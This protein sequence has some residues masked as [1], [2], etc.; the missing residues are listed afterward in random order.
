MAHNGLGVNDVCRSE[1]KANVPKAEERSD[2]AFTP[3][4]RLKALAKFSGETRM[5]S[6]IFFNNMELSGGAFCRPLERFV[7]HKIQYFRISNKNNMSIYFFLIQCHQG[8]TTIC[9]LSE[10]I[11]HGSNTL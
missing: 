9:S 3:C 2:A 6:M 8:N 11:S 4:Y 10:D 7:M 1:T 5:L